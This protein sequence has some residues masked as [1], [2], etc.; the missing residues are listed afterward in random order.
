MG[1][2]ESLEQLSLIPL[3]FAADPSIGSSG[4]SCSTG[5]HGEAGPF[6]RSRRLVGLPSFFSSSPADRGRRRGVEG[7]E[8]PDESPALLEEGPARLPCSRGLAAVRPRGPERL[9]AKLVTAA[10][11]ER[12]NPNSVGV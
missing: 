7:L 10:L 11:A 4:N 1:S 3:A 5:W 12:T 9:L 8:A 6:D 2:F